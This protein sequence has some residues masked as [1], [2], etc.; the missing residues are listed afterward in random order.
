MT[1]NCKTEHLKRE[2]FISNTH[3]LPHAKMVHWKK[4]N[5]MFTADPTKLT[6]AQAS[7]EKDS[8]FL[9]VTHFIQYV[10]IFTPRTDTLIKLKEYLLMQSEPAVRKVYFKT[11]QNHNVVC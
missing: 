9:Y 4:S 5:I 3:D 8:G 6:F 11:E 10:G 2:M 1:R 7:T